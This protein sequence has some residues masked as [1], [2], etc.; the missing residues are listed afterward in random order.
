MTG[1]HTQR[2]A[3]SLT[4]GLPG[5]E[6]ASDSD[7]ELDWIAFDSLIRTLV[8]DFRQVLPPGWTVGGSA[9]SDIHLKVPASRSES[10]IQIRPGWITAEQGSGSQRLQRVT[11][12]M[13]ERL[14]TAVSDTTGQR[15]PVTDDGQQ[16]PPYAQIIPQ[17]ENTPLR[18]GY[19]TPEAPV[20]RIAD[21]DPLAHMIVHRA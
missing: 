14:Q 21:P 20:L 16:A 17:R 9:R 12:W 2:L 4:R 7:H 19:G 13:L 18:L 8:L 5:T 10:D 3:R 6:H 11:L 1:P 15:W